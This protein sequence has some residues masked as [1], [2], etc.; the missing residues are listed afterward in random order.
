VTV[1]VFDIVA[2][3]KY[4]SCSHDLFFVQLSLCWYDTWSN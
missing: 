1:S 4:S 2:F 3:R